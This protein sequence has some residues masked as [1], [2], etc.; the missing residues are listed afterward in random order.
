MDT[1][2]GKY[3]F[4]SLNGKSA[5][6][7]ILTNG[8]LFNKHLGMFVDED[9][10]MLNVSDH[11]LIRAWF[12]IG[13]SNYKKPPKKKTLKEITWIS[14]EQDRVNLCVED[15]KTKIGRKISFRGCMNKIKTSVEYA[16]RRRSKYSREWR[17]AR[18]RGDRVEEIEKCKQKYLLQKSKTALMTGDK[19]KP[20][21][22][23]EDRRNM[24]GQ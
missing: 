10:V 15:F 21:G 1:C 18:K 4:E 11:N 17:Y 5:I 2:I 14:R 22:G 20:M 13:N 8:T 6:D 19:K 9:K 3:T 24:E 23:K 12:Q 16:M 7:H